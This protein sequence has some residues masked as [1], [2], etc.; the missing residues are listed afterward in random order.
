[1]AIL[2]DHTTRVLIQGVGRAGIFHAEQCLNYGT[3]VVA[4]V[5]P[6]KKENLP[7]P[8]FTTVAEAKKATGCDTSLLFVPAPRAAEAILEAE[9][10]SISLIIC[11]TEGIPNQDMLR[12]HRVLKQS[13][14]KL[15]GPNCPGVMAPGVAKL[16][17]MP[18]YIYRPGCV[19]IVSRS[20]TLGYEAAWQI[21]QLG[22]GQSTCV[23]IGGDPLI[24]T[25]FLEVIE[26]FEADPQTEAILLVGEV[27]GEEEEIA[28]EWIR[29]HSVK[30][31]VA[32]IAGA[33]S[34]ID[35]RMGHAGA[36]MSRGYGACRE[37]IEALKEAGV[38]IAPTA[39]DMGKRIK[40]AIERRS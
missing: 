9:A 7:F 20:G 21:T 18:D 23:G 11:I 5:T 38:L 10:A 15:I 25:S 16:G 35:R 1:M 32:F 27:G 13:K 29:E 17:I 31:V 26:L 8:L 30:P 40:Y 24:G 6:K 39:S 14:T 34:P 36:M 28:A 33:C 4:G 12:V 37:K 3:K 22:L 2:V 19:G